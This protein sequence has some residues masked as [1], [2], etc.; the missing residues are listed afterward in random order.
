MPDQEKATVTLQPGA[1]RLL[2]KIVNGAWKLA[3]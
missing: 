2:V 3:R 1:N